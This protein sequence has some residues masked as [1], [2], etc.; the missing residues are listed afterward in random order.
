MK[1]ICVFTG[2][3]AEYGL[4]RPVMRRIRDDGACRLAT[5][6]TGAHL[7]LSTGHTVD[8]ME[9]DGMP[10]DY[11]VETLMDGDD[12][13]AVCTAMGLG[14][15]RYGDALAS[16]RPDI[17]V[18]LGDRYEALALAAATTV[19][20]VP[21]AHIHGGETTLGAMDETFRHAVT[22]MSHLHFTSCEAYRN[23]VV[24]LGEAPERVWNVG[25]LGVENIHRLPLPDERSIRA[26][27]D[28]DG[29]TPYILCTLHPE[30]RGGHDEESLCR[31]FLNALDRFPHHAVVFTGANT[32]PG[33]G[34]V[35][36]VLSAYAERHR[37][38]CRFF[39]SLGVANYLAAAAHAACVAGNSSSGILEVP[40]LKTPVVDIG[41]RQEGRIRSAAVLHSGATGE[42]IAK[43]VETALTEA[44]RRAAAEAS[45]PYDKPGTAENICRTLYEN[46]GRTTLKKPFYDLPRPV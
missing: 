45:N 31:E 1:T 35:N 43:A 9:A 36:A 38:R 15:M 30:T 44:H 46:I 21:V 8:E 14:I 10:V 27:L 2:T 4:L 18:V 25:S 29:T 34:R 37:D 16:L 20:G 26:R 28:L 39:M 40:S 42:A 6:V 33:G 41:E 23:R 12:R 22:K 17:V 11:R 19:H 24:Q 7:G 3:R 13:N 32:D 5:I